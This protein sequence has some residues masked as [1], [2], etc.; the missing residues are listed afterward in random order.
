MGLS[1]QEYSLLTKIANQTDKTRRELEKLKKEDLETLWYLVGELKHDS[2]HH[3]IKPDI[4]PLNRYDVQF[5]ERDPMLEQIKQ[6]TFQQE[7]KKLARKFGI[8]NC[9][10]AYSEH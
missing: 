6:N 9:V 10:V 3:G 8:K 1:K 7:F 4:I 2:E 5:D